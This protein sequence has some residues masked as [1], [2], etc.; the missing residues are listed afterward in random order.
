MIRVAVTEMEYGKSRGVFAAAAQEGL[1]CRAAPSGE[2]AL[3]D[4]VRRHDVRHV[5]V[6]VEP[7]A[8]PLY[9]ALPRG[10]V[11]ARFGV[12]HDNVDKA[13]ATAHGI[14][15]TNTPGALDDSVA[16]HAVN[17]MLAAARLTVPAAN[18][19]RGG[20]WSAFVGRELAGKTMAVIGCGAI[21]RRVAR[22]AA[23]GLGMRV[24]GCEVAAV[25]EDRLRAEFG[26]E[27]VSPDF[28]AV[29]ADADY[30]SLHIP[31]TPATRH[32]INAPRLALL[33]P[34]AWLI[35]T[36]RG[37]VVDEQALFDAL[38]AGRLAGAALDV[39]ER[40]PYVPV[41][42]AKDLRTL[43]NTVL[44]PHIGS[45]T[46]E[47]CDRMATIALRNVRLALAGRYLDM[48]LLNPEVIPHLTGG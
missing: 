45:S 31:S 39:F 25:D 44:T 2:P 30:I 40:E 14:L 22:I 10:G 28:A 12:G 43:P 13:A 19:A 47:A 27:R 42:P 48:N 9:E 4:F 26:F 5:I 6:G 7:Y 34:R 37:A 35:N 18:C 1:D 46:Q 16:E 41:H 11:L 8:G 17:L 29:V 3:T 32:F 24:S 15:C 36:A 38:S 21:G 33:P 20:S 23:R